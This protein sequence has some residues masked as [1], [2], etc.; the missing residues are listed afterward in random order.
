MGLASITALSHRARWRAP[1]G[2]SLRPRSCRRRGGLWRSLRQAWPEI[3]GE[4]LAKVCE[5]ISLEWARGPRTGEDE[6]QPATLVVRVEG[7]FGLEV[8][9][10]APALLERINSHFGWR[11]AGKLAIRQGRVSPN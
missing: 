3:V 7:A 10:L 9:H 2:S 11:C 6:R 8:Q 1:P 4:R 5:P